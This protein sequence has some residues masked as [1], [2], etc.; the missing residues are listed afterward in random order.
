M[1]S[2]YGPI[3]ILILAVSFGALPDQKGQK[4]SRASSIWENSFAIT[5]FMALF[6]VSLFF[7]TDSFSPPL[8]H[9]LPA[10]FGAGQVTS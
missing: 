7:S 10:P 1:T 8:Y 6:W 5:F 3:N 4:L 9:S 2:P